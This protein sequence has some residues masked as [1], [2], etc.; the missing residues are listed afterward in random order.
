MIMCLMLSC[1]QVAH[2]DL[3]P[4]SESFVLPAFS[5]LPFSKAMRLL[6]LTVLDVGSLEFSYSVLAAS[7]LYHTENEAIALSV[8]GYQWRDIAACVR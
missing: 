2:G 1:P 5:G 6:D 8:S 7:A 4:C 3:S